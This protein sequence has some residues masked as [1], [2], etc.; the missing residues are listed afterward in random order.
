MQNKITV[1]ELNG[2]KSLLKTQDNLIFR[3]E[4]FSKQI[5][6]P[7]LKSEFQKLYSSAQS[8]KN[9]LLSALDNKSE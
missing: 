2:I 3:F 1:K 9:K 4:Q 8:H 7:Q 6:E 5:K